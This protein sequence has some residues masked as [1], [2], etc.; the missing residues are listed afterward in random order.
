LPQADDPA[1]NPSDCLVPAW[2]DVQLSTELSNPDENS[3]VDD[4]QSSQRLTVSLNLHRA[5]CTSLISDLTFI[6]PFDVRAIDGQDNRLRTDDLSSG[7]RHY[8]PPR[9]SISRSMTDRP[10]R[11]SVSFPMDPAEGY[12]RMFK[13]LGFSFYSLTAE[14]FQYVEM[15]FQASDQWIEILPQYRLKIEEAVSEGDSYSYRMQFK[16]TGDGERPSSHISV[17]EDEPLPKYWDMGLKLLNAD[18][19]DVFDAVSSS[20]GGSSRGTSGSGSNDTYT[21]SGHGECGGCGGVKTIQFKFA[22]NL[23]E[24]ELSYVLKDIPVPTF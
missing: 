9:E 14:Y 18:G 7:F 6:H 17:R 12:P 2:D 4:L 13:E 22:V 15:P 20:G 10:A 16:Y 1:W 21:A 3:G 8:S 23:S 5:A 11:L 19:K 24:V